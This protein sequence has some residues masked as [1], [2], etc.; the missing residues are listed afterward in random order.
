MNSSIHCQ[1]HLQLAWSS[2]RSVIFITFFIFVRLKKKEVSHQLLLLE[3]NHDFGV[4]SSIASRFKERGIAN[5]IEKLNSFDLKSHLLPF[6][7]NHFKCYI[8]SVP[9]HTLLLLFIFFL[10]L[11]FFCWKQFISI[12]SGPIGWCVFCSRTEFLGDKQ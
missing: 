8:W 11:I 7:T 5:K 2:I 10:L 1:H 9:F 12:T 3:Q 4:C 6:L